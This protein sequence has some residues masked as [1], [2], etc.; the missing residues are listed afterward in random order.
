[1]YGLVQYVFVSEVV[2]VPELSVLKV[3]V[4][5]HGKACWHSLRSF[6]QDLSKLLE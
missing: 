6:K 4:L 1:M 5:F 2:H 3:H